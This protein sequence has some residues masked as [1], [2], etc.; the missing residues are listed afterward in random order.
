MMAPR[1]CPDPG[2]WSLDCEGMLVRADTT[3]IDGDT[4]NPVVSPI[5]V[6]NSMLAQASSCLRGA[7]HDRRHASSADQ[8]P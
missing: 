4:N 8:S 7:L 6:N 1:S 2:P 3:A 5:S